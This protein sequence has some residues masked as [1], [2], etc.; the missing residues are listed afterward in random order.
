MAAAV[1]FAA[2]G[3]IAVVAAVEGPTK[4]WIADVVIVAVRELHQMAYYWGI[5]LPLAPVETRLPR[6]H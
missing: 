4:K 6:V 2:G 3:T 1:V 5:Q